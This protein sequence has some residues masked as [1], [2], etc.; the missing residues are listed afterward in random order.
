MP[1]N[2]ISRYCHHRAP[3]LRARERET[4]KNRGGER[5][6]KKK[7]ALVLFYILSIEEMTLFMLITEPFHPSEWNDPESQQIRPS[8]SVYE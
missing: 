8:G 5:K 2:I 1:E 6:K 7:G 3:L 4:E